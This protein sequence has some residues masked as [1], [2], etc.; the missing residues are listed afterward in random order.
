[1]TFTTDSDNCE[2]EI[3][4]DDTWVFVFTGLD[5]NMPYYIWEEDYDGYESTNPKDNYAVVIPSKGDEDPLTESENSVITVT[6]RSTDD[7]PPEPSYGSLKIYKLLRGEGL[8]D[9]DTSRS[10]LFTVTLTDE[11]DESLSG[12]SVYG[13]TAFR[14]GTAAVRLT[15][16]SDITIT[17][18]PAGWHYSVSETPVDGFTS[19]TASSSGVIAADE[20]SEV[21]YTNTKSYTE[22]DNNSFR[23]KKLVKGNYELEDHEFELIISLIGLRVGQTYSL[24][25]GTEFTADNY[26][27]AIVR[28]TLGNNDEVT[29]KDIPIGAEYR[30]T[31]PA[32]SYI[33]SY[34][35]ENS[36]DEGE[37]FQS[38]GN[39]T[40]AERALS[41]LTETVDKGEDILVTFTNTLDIRQPLTLK[42]VVLNSSSS[43]QDRFEFTVEITGLAQLEQ[44]ST[45]TMGSFRADT[46]GRLTAQLYL[47]N[48][49]TVT[50][51][52]LPVKAKYRITE[53]ES[54]CLATYEITDS[55]NKG[56]IEKASDSSDDISS[57]LSTEWE[58]V[59]EG[60]NVSVIFTNTKTDREISVTKLVDMTY[61]LKKPSEYYSE[62]FSFT[63]ELEGLAPG[64]EYTV[65][66]TARNTTG[67]LSE[68]TFTAPESGS[69]VFSFGLS[70]GQTAS[71][72]GLP[73]NASYRIT[74]QA[75]PFYVPSYK[76]TG[77]EGAVIAAA[78]GSA[79]SV[80]TALSTQ[81]EAVD[82][83]D[84][85]VNIEFTNTYSKP[86]YVLPD[87]GTNDIR[88]FLLFSGIGVLVF[89]AAFAYVSREKRSF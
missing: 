70:H 80:G 69:A 17:G 82:T 36:A 68:E 15:G 24:S 72:R 73:L 49:E 18:I 89:A 79:D 7:P 38:S 54:F 13:N 45:D 47:G 67:V 22:E 19:E 6:N 29:V 74:E 83:D 59:N 28:I 32:G 51:R 30:I 75:V 57:P 39:N 25:D 42:K 11:N 37:I 63:A 35:I 46:G 84:H 52:G 5:P 34:I 44:I 31:E 43:S 56:A 12:T 23:I 78:S 27:R 85:D 20:I 62:E 3:Q 58:T 65:Q 55:N 40:T 76:I 9:E 60:E 53:K 71:F 86:N 41:T 10:F 26:G 14:D 66:Y 64:R 61:G 48:D 1:M 87:A 21:L 88:Y 16:G 2:V 81:T 4:D 77:N 33:S 50:F 8:T